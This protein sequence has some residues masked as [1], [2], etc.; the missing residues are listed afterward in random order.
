MKLPLFTIS[1]LYRTI[2]FVILHSIV[3]ELIPKHKEFSAVAK[4]Q[5][6]EE[7]GPKI[8]EV[9][10]I[11]EVLKKTLKESYEKKEAAMLSQVE[12][13]EV[14]K[15]E[16][17]KKEEQKKD[18]MLSQAAQKEMNAFNAPKVEKKEPTLNELAPTKL[19]SQKQPATINRTLH[20]WVFFF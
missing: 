15:K 18:T 3:V 7:F 4:A 12:K 9:M 11:L 13:K 6:N 17:G 2:L 19:N 1:S 16:G 5:L 20:N 8:E 14:E 10:K